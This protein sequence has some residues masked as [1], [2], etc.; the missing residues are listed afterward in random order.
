MSKDT[1]I[2]LASRHESDQPQP[3]A[4]RSHFLEHQGETITLK[5]KYAQA[6]ALWDLLASVDT[7]PPHGLLEGHHAVCTLVR[8]L[9]SELPCCHTESG[10]IE[11]FK[12]T[13]DGRL[14]VNPGIPNDAAEFF[15]P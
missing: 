11:I 4:M 8:S 2:N 13:T 1:L 5:L 9:V 12:V 7:V 15:Q 6:C 10:E 3:S 14:V